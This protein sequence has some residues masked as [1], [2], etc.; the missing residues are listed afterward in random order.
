M[1]LTDVPA[2]AF[3]GLETLESIS[4]YDNKLVRIPQLALQKVPNLK[5]LDLNKNPVQKL[6]E[7]DFHRYALDNL[8][9]FTKLEATN[10]PKLSYVHKQAFRDLPSLESVMLNHN[11][12][13]ALYRS[14]VE[15]LPN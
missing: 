6:Q 3:I 12:L 1:D 14:S 8:P 11:A 5:F 4:F 7:G 9:E 13:T 15:A 2:D 10:N